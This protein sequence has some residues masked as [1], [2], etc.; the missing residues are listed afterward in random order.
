VPAGIEL[1]DGTLLEL[2]AIVYATGFDAMT[3]ALSRIDVRGRDGRR[4]GDQW[5]AS[6]T[7]YLGVAVAGFPNLFTVTG[8]GSPSVLTNMVTSIEHHV[9]WITTLLGEMRASGQRLVEASA[10]AQDEWADHVT[11]QAGP[12]QVHETCT[13][14][15]LGANVPGKTRAYMPYSAGLDV[16]MA[17]CATVADDGYP[18]FTRD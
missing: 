8:P 12:I 13:S 7:A 15:Y 18:G 3:G 2:D 6:P 16:Y 11:S 1:G 4:L 10:D 17:H 14:W 5:A 9:E